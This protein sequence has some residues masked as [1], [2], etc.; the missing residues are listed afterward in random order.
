MRHTVRLAFALVVASAL[1]SCKSTTAP[2][3]NFTATAMSTGVRLSNQ[4]NSTVFYMMVDPHMLALLDFIPC[5]SRSIGC[6][7]VAAHATVDA[8]RSEIIGNHDDLKEV[9]V[10]YWTV[11]EQITGDKLV[12][13]G[14]LTV[15]LQ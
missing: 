11:R 8:A 15:E 1:A 4:G 2:H 12:S 6:K 7:F 14:S 10:L 9:Q 3:E 13:Q 5:T